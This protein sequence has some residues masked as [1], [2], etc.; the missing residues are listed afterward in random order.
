MPTSTKHTTKRQASILA[1]RIN[2]DPRNDAYEAHGL[3]EDAAGWY[4][5]V[6]DSQ[7]TRKN[8]TG[9][10]LAIRSWSEWEEALGSR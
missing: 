4:V 8:P 7:A 9:R 10:D 3:S 6:S 1:N 2:A 5:C